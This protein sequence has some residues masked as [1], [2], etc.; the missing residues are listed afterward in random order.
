MW[1]T[2]EPG[3]CVLV[4][5]DTGASIDAGSMVLVRDP[6]AAE[7][8]LIKRI[9]SGGPGPFSVSSDNALEGRDSRHFGLLAWVEG[10]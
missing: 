1:P 5:P 3:D 2:L 9:T 10:R 6:G 4:D 7:R 8:T